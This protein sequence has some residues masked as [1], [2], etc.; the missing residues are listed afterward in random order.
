MKTEPRLGIS[1]ILLVL[2]ASVFAVGCGKK[3]V[4]QGITLPDSSQIVSD[5]TLIEEDETEGSSRNKDYAPEAGIQTVYFDFD[6]SELSFETRKALQENAAVI[7]KRVG[8]EIQV[9]GHCDE[10][11]TTEYNIALGQRRA[12]VIRNY[13]K[14][15]GIKITSM[16]TIS[17]GEEN[18]VCLETADECR[19]QN[20]RGETLIRTR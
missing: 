11:G 17:Y 4:K 14:A 2:L 13:Y 5:A 12:N 9:A 3:N 18:P 7:K 16:A 19:A 8:V 10:R 20:R 15:L 6:K 1:Q